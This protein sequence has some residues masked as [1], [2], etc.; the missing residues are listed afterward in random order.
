MNFVLELKFRVRT[1]NIF[2]DH[3]GPLVLRFSALST[4]THCDIIVF[5]FIGKNNLQKLTHFTLFDRRNKRLQ[6]SFLKEN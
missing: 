5:T 6:S 2:M 4:H 3:V 1:W